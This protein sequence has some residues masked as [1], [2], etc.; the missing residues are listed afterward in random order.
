MRA[1]AA[2][3]LAKFEVGEG[4]YNVIV[5]FTVRDTGENNAMVP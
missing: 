5:N 2:A 1:L 3:S 4:V